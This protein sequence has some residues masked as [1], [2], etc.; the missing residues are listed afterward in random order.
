MATRLW[1]SV[2]AFP[3]LPD[4]AIFDRF[5]AT[6]NDPTVTVQGSLAVVARAPLYR[7]DE[8]V[9]LVQSGI[10]NPQS[11]IESWTSNA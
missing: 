3:S 8:F 7:E 10:P 4:D 1:S 5:A 11:A 9:G 6:V 2:L